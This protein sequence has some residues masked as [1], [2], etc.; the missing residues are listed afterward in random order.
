MPTCAHAHMH[1]CVSTAPMTHTA[2]NS[3]T[4]YTRNTTHTTHATCIARAAARHTRHAQHAHLRLRHTNLRPHLLAHS[5]T[6]KR[7]HAHAHARAHTRAQLRRGF[8]P[9]EGSSDLAG[10]VEDST[11]TAC[12]GT[13]CGTAATCMPLSN[14]G[15]AHLC[16]F[17]ESLTGPGMSETR[18]S[19]RVA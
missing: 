14:R 16:A 1:V 13:T 11:A 2:H 12:S 10:A 18:M 9:V 7:T 5:L 15:Q 4:R 6:Q 19:R 17:V 8:S 3:H